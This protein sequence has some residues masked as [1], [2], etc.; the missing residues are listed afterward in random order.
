[1][2]YVTST[3][4]SI[5]DNRYVA[6]SAKYGSGH[7]LRNRSA[8]ANKLSLWSSDLSVVI[9]YTP[10]GCLRERLMHT[11][12]SGCTRLDLLRAVTRFGVDYQLT[13]SAVI[14]RLT[15]KAL[16]DPTAI[17]GVPAKHGGI[18]NYV[19]NVNKESYL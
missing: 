11:V 18:P 13:F 7:A 8:K 4:P 3:I 16:L 6:E 9:H 14:N 15:V 17:E 19:L 5:I 1:M 12:I 10:N 2:A